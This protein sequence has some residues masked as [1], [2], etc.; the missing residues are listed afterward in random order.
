MKLRELPKE[1]R[2]LAEKIINETLFLAEMGH[3]TAS[4]SVGNNDFS[5]TTFTWEPQTQLQPYTTD[6]SAASFLSNYSDV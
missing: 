2:I 6:D 5:N 1:Q 3:L 4:H